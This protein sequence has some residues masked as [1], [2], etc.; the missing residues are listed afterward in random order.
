M[1]AVRDFFR[2]LFGRGSGQAG[3]PTPARGRGGDE[4]IYFYVKLKQTGEVV[5]LRLIPRQ[6]LVPDYQVGGYFSRKVI[7]GPRTLARANA[8]FRFDENRRFTDAEIAGGEL[9]DEG[10]YRSVEQSET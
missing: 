7:T 10:E 1:G 2:S 4:G 3:G 9:T 6:E 8:L 5:E